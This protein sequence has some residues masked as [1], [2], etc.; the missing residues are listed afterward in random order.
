MPKFTYCASDKAF[1]ENITLEVTFLNLKIII[2]I[3]GIKLLRI[4]GDNRV[5]RLPVLLDKIGHMNTHL[6]RTVKLS[7]RSSLQLGVHSIQFPLVFVLLVFPNTFLH[8]C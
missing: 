4:M 5:L 1:E 2:N 6:I 3:F 7:E 8:L